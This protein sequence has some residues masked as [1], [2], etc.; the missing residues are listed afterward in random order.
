MGEYARSL[1][2]ALAA[3]ARWP[4]ATVHFLVSA[5]APYAAA[6]PFEHTLLPASPTMHSGGVIACMRGFRPDAVIFDNAGRTAQ[7]AAAHGLGA[8]VIYISSRAR[9]RRKG[10][11]WRWMGLLDEHWIAYPEFVAGATTPI[12]RLKLAL[13][14]GPRL[15]YL[16]YILSQG[17]A[18]DVPVPA[19]PFA[20][21]VPGGGTGHPGA[22]DSVR[23]FAAAAAGLGA[24]GVRTIFV[25][26][27]RGSALAAGAP[28][29]QAFESLPQ[30]GLAALLR[31]A[32][33]V[34]VNGGS[35]LL[36]A[37]AAGRACVAVA[38][39]KDQ[40]QRIDRCVAAGVAR[41][42]SLQAAAITAAALELW[43]DEPARRALA[44]RA[45]SLELTDGIEV[46]LQGLSESLR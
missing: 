23:R 18:A 30:R 43:H 40:Q 24:A 38:I 29:V 12:E 35:T 8:A 42:A 13:R 15:R 1:S 36:Q 31:A 16:D 19:E 46:A 21:V 11:R 9:Q 45:A 34:V 7:L 27:T 33:L 22:V 4:E 20:L 17:P 44:G 5:Q 41:E 3:Q 6:T 37:I 25:G 39:A 28:N 26:P 10:F 32:G 14:G 2:I